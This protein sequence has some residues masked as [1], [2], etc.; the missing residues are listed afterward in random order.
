MKLLQF[1]STWSSLDMAYFH[2][3]NVRNAHPFAGQGSIFDSSTQWQT[4]FW[5][6]K[7]LFQ[8]LGDD[9]TICE[10]GFGA[11]YSAL[12][13]LSATTSGPW[14]KGAKFVEFELSLNSNET[15]GDT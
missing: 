4:Y 5:E 14:K 10:V 15:S 7:K 11:G 13:L 12:M 6:A 2:M 1:D 9:M 8:K 3:L